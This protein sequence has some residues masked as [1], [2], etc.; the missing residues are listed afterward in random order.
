MINYRK[1]KERYKVNELGSL[2]FDRENYDSSRRPVIYIGGQ[3]E[4]RLHTLEQSGYT[5]DEG[6][7]MFDGSWFYDYSIFAK[8]KADFNSK[9][10]GDNL[11]ESL[12]EAGLDE[13]DLITES[14][15]GMIGLYTTVSPRIHKVVAIHPPILG[16]PLANKDLLN[17]KYA[18]LS[19]EHRAL[20]RIID[21][22]IDERYGFEQENSK[23]IYSTVFALENIDL[24][25]M[26]VV[27]SSINLETERN[28]LVRK[29]ANLIQELAGK[30]SDGVVV[31]EPSELE[32]IG[33]KYY[34][35]PESLNHFDAGSKENIEKAYVRV[36][37]R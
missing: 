21:L 26:V 20:S 25:K 15:G 8:N 5:A 11:L 6:H 10:F 36:L 18:S 28:P 16:S 35:E 31:F 4:H 13:V 9:N 37:K 14:Y 17:Q 23:G 3:M 12:E 1:G 34:V 24:D 32:K 19:R 2:Y 22:L 7:N 30:N 33:V 27:G 29:T